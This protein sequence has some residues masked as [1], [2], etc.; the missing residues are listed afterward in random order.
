VLKAPGA[1]IQATC[2]PGA[3]DLAR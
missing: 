2:Q 1:A 3:W